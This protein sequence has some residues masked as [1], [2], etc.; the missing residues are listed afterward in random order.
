MPSCQKLAAFV[1]PCHSLENVNFALTDTSLELYF[2]AY[3]V[4]PYAM[5]AP[6]VEIEYDEENFI[7]KL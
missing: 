4:G 5:G 7:I 2:N 1:Q 3:D 6:M